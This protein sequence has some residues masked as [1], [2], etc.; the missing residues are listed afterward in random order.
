MD[1]ANTIAGG[2]DRSR[3]AWEWALLALAMF[4]GPLAWASHSASIVLLVPAACE[5]GGTWPHWV[6]TGVALAVTFVALALSYRIWR[7]SSREPGQASPEE[8][9]TS[10]TAASARAGFLSW[11][12]LFINTMFLGLIVIESIP[13]A[14]LGPCVP[15]P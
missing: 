2:S 9:D 1:N 3:S 15:H 14:W 10:S 6:T 4:G 11:G 8:A 5:A 13:L 7:A 12:G